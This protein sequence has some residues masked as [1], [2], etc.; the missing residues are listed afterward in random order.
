MTTRTNLLAFMT[1]APDGKYDATKPTDEQLA[2]V[3]PWL[4]DTTIRWAKMNGHCDTVNSAIH[5]VVTDGKAWNGTVYYYAA[6]GLDCYGYNKDGRD[7]DGF[8]RNGY[9]LEGYHRRGYHRDTG[10]N[11]E[12][13]NRYG[14]DKDGFNRDGFNEYGHTREQAVTKLVSGW[15]K[16]HLDLVAAKLAER[17]AAKAAVE[18]AAVAVAVAVAEAAAEA[19]AEAEAAAAAEAQAVADAAEAALNTAPAVEESVG[20]AA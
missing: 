20:A 18:A 7:G 10:F 5:N 1:D 17:I 3:L 19:A 9:D 12:G 11:R 8:D 13:F 16:P 2:A 15:T 4:I 6:N 14:F